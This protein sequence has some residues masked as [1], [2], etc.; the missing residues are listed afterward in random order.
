[1]SKSQYTEI[2]QPD[3]RSFLEMATLGVLGVVVGTSETAFIRSVFA[4]TASSGKELIVH[5]TSPMNAEPALKDLVQSWITPVKYFYVRSHAPT[6]Q[7]DI[8]TFR[9]RVEGLVDKPREF[10]VA[11]LKERFPA[12]SAVVTM[13]CA[14]NRRSE[15]S[16]TKPVSGVQWGAGPIGNAKWS[17][18][19]LWALL[20][21]IGIKPGASHIWFESVDRV[22]KDGE[23]IP[24]GG[25]IPIGMAVERKGGVRGAIV[26]F[27]MNDAPLAPDHGYPVRMVVPGVIG[28]RSVK[29]LGKIVVSDRPSPNH[30][31][32]GA[33]KLVTDDQDDAWEAARPIY[34]FPVNSAICT[35]AE[36]AKLKSGTIRVAGYALPAGSADRQISRVQVSTDGGKHWT[37]A[38]LGP[39]SRD[40]CW[41]LWHADVHVTPKTTQ[42]IVRAFDNG[43]A[44][45]PE[46]AKWNLKGYL[47][48][49]WHRVGVDVT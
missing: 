27:E 6:P 25:S 9:I 10:S 35:P 12:T 16:L 14:G 4:D 33:Y 37:Q 22:E 43:G 1:M 23:T 13:T 24:F 8:D 19:T 20:E 45:Q 3:R 15:H 34:Y 11:E 32:A 21:E 29:W 28:A 42:L 47:Y 31:V 30:Y 7:L 26:A 46:T 49:A 48:N 17:G 40:F 44:S 5:S 18:V 41:R 2:H 38:E 39:E 36:N